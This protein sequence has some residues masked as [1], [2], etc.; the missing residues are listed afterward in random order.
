[1][2]NVYFGMA[3]IFDFL[4]PFSQASNL[5]ALSLYM[6]LGFVKDEKMNKYYLNGGDA[7]RLKLWVDKEVPAST[8]CI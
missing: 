7:Y 8:T 2:L 1:V 3:L 4:F 6:K 5:G